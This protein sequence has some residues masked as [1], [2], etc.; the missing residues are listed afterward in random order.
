MYKFFFSLRLFGE[1]SGQMFS[2]SWGCIDQLIT[3]C[4]LIDFPENLRKYT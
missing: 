4:M 2:E 3:A 1:E